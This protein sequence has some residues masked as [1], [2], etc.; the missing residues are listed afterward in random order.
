MR[1]I[2]CRLGGRTAPWL[3]GVKSLFLMALLQNTTRLCM[4]YVPIY[5]ICI[6]MYITGYFLSL[7]FRR[8]KHL[9]HQWLVSKGSGIW[10]SIS[11]VN[12]TLGHY[13]LDQ[14]GSEQIHHWSSRPLL[15]KAL[16]H[17][18]ELSLSSKLEFPTRSELSLHLKQR[19]EAGKQNGFFVMPAD[20]AIYIHVFP[21]G[22]HSNWIFGVSLACLWHIFGISLA[23]L[24][25][26]FVIS[27]LDL[28]RAPRCCFAFP[29]T[30]K[31]RFL[32]LCR[33]DKSS[34]SMN[35]EWK[36]SQHWC[37][38]ASYI[39]THLLNYVYCIY[40]YICV[41]IYIYVIYIQYIY[42]CV[43]APVCVLLCLLNDL[44]GKYK[45]RR[46]LIR[47]TK[48]LLAPGGSGSGRTSLQEHRGTWGNAEHLGTSTIQPAIQRNPLSNWCTAADMLFGPQL[49]A[50]DRLCPAG[51][52]HMHHVKVL[53]LVILY[54]LKLFICCQMDHCFEYIQEGKVRDPLTVYP[55]YPADLIWSFEVKLPL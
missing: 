8:E 52:G 23:Y 12:T 48:A 41:Y 38:G 34:C 39:Y 2:R 49:L 28:S 15:L 33:A 25:S 36:T 14:L 51:P 44:Q 55:I 11:D 40:I 24:A 21:S 31:S 22:C 30:T 32:W 4:R 20:H 54:F 29:A 27:G 3:T 17:H 5:D 47:Y 46:L 53:A 16:Q 50:G 26:V 19:V 7:K 43:C 35:P 6:H 1:S 45:S 13:Q 9:L 37:H 18:A 10:T 42:M